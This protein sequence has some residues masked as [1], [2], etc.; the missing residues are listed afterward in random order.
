MNEETRTQSGEHPRSFV[1]KAYVL[2]NAL[3]V[4]LYIVFGACSL[5]K[6]ER[7]PPGENEKVLIRTLQSSFKAPLGLERPQGGVYM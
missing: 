3:H 1:T 6:E 7:S 5:G 2:P 4:T